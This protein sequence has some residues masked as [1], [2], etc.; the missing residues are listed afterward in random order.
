MSRQKLSN[1]IFAPRPYCPHLPPVSRLDLVKLFF[2]K[3]FFRKLALEMA[4]R[5]SSGWGPQPRKRE[6]LNRSS[7]PQKLL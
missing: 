7:S 2:V 6:K 3:L 5:Q 1:I 4:T